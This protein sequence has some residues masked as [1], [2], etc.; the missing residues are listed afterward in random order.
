MSGR[1]GYSLYLISLLSGLI[2]Q[3]VELPDMLALARPMWIPLLLAGWML[4]APQL[5]SLLMALLLG[6]CMDVMLNCPLGQHA[7]G[8]VV[9]VYIIARMR[10]ALLLY[11]RWQTTVV[12]APLWAGYALLLGVIDE[13]THHVATP[14]LRWWPLLPTTLLWPLID[15]WLAS[16]NHHRPSDAD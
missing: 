11:P 9:L 5:P 15:T 13:L 6:L 2:L 14:S 7:L 10:P 4:N 16:L 3:F 8:L 1:A 12:L